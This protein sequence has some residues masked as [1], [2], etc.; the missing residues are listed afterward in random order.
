MKYFKQID[1]TKVNA[2][3]HT[4]DQLMKYP[5]LKVFIGTDSQVYG[6]DIVY[7]T[8]IVYRYGNNGC[9]YIYNKQWKKRKRVLGKNNDGVMEYERLYEEGVRTIEVFDVITNE[10]P[11]SIE[12]LEFDYQE[13][14]KTVSQKLVSQFRGWVATMNTKGVFKSGCMMATKAADHIIRHS[15]RRVRVEE[16]IAEAA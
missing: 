10:V 14:S 6:D 15:S 9:H 1:G 16:D 11:V 5:N 7:V 13:V 4:L 3:K 12:A 8:A 2:V